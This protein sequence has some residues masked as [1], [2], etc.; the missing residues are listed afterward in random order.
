MDCNNCPCIQSLLQQGP[1]CNKQ[2]QLYAYTTKKKLHL[3]YSTLSVWQLPLTICN[4]I[5]ALPF[6]WEHWI[7][8]SCHRCFIWK[9]RKGK[10]RKGR[11]FIQRHISTHAYSQSAQTWITQFYLQITP[12]LPYLRNLSPDGA[13]ANWGS[14]H[15][16]AAYYSFIDPEGMKGWVGLVDRPIVDGLPT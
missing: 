11:V 2:P 8:S 13:T 16:I 9:E 14:R 3:K 15:R 1:S 4:L 5:V 6:S 12:C 10:E 7:S